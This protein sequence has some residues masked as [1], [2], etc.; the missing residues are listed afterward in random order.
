[1]TT[2]EVAYTEIEQ[3]V[4]RFKFLS[5]SER[6]G[7]NEHATRQGYI[8]PL[9]QVLG[10]KVDNVHEA[11]PQEKEMLQSEIESTD[12]AIDALVYQLHGLNEAE[13]KIVKGK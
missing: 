4:Q 11:S 1:M 13:I 8:L 7:M 2:P 12:Q 3:L 9:F 6:R 5:A 10:W